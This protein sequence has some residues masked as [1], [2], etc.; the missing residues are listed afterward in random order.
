M[1]IEGVL[2]TPQRII[3]VT[4]GDVLHAMKRGDVGECGFG[5][6]YFSTVEQGAVKAWKRHRL[7]TMNLVVPVGQIRFVMYDDRPGAATR[8]VFQDVVLSTRHYSRLTVAPMVWI[9]FQGLG[10]PL[11]LLLNVASI[12]HD[13][14]ETERLDVG[15]INYEWNKGL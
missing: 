10:S 2:L 14:G 11:N 15:A 8:G 6:A 7:V 12:P 9:G 5:E 13:P 1:T 4:G 3:T